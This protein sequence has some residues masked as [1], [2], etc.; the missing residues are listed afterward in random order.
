MSIYSF[1]CLG[2]HR[3][4]CRSLCKPLTYADFHGCCLVEVFF[5]GSQ[6]FMPELNCQIIGKVYVCYVG[7]Y[8]SVIKVYEGAAVTYIHNHHEQL[9]KICIEVL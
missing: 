2:L 9:C 4:N 1:L 8:I 6:H 7:N 3:Y 5:A